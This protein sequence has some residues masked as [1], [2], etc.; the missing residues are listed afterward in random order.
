MD[1]QPRKAL[2]DEVAKFDSARR[3]T[4]TLLR[5]AQDQTKDLQRP[6]LDALTKAHE[7]AKSAREASAVTLLG[8]QQ[9]LKSI[10]DLKKSS[11]HATRASKL[12]R[13]TTAS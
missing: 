12:P 1:E 7:S 8:A 9:E 5:Q 4:G 2:Q 6:D 10:D 11:P 13:P 3:E